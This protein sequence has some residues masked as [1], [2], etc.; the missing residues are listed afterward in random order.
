[1]AAIYFHSTRELIHDQH[2]RMIKNTKQIILFMGACVPLRILI[3]WSS[4]KIPIKYLQIYGSVFL[5]MSIGILYLYFTGSRMQ[6]AEANGP[7]W[8]AQY[9]LIIGL[10]WL[11]AAVYAFQ[12]RRDLVWV[13]L[14]IDIL[15]GLVIFYKKH[16]L[17]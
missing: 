13:P 17:V 5:A 3:A 1:M 15:F 12:G 11:A 14:A 8:W 9:R 2:C 10:L 7:T 16:F 4:T 6:A